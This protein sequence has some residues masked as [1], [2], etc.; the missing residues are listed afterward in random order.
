MRRRRFDGVGFGPRGSDL[1]EEP[2]RAGGDNGSRGG[3]LESQG[4]E[5]ERKSKRGVVRL[6]SRTAKRDQEDRGA[7]E[8]QAGGAG[9]STALRS[10]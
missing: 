8:R 9:A 1:L 5:G 10:L 4:P 2:V 3:E 6:H 7:A